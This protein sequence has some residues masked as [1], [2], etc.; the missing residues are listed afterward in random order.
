MIGQ[1]TEMEQVAALC[2]QDGGQA[3]ICA[4]DVRHYDQV[5]A[6]AEHAVRT[7]GSLDIWVNN[8]G[9]GYIMKPL[10]EVSPADW[11]A[12][13]DVNLTGAFFGLRVAAEHMVSAGRGGRIVNIASQAAKSGFAHAQAYTASKHGLVGLVRSA[14]IELGP[15]GI[16]VNNV[17]PN[18]V[19]TGLG[20]WQND[21]FAKVTGHD[22]VDSYLAAMARRIPMGRAGLVEDTASAVAFLCSEE[23]AYITAESMNVSGGEEPH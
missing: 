22:T 16:T 13:I 10:L 5:Q 4:C 3:S 21:Y 2:R 14:A 17:C 12:V 15:Y 1:S 8:A 18:H 23:A 9:I 11:S 7:H 6:L 20:A 19:T